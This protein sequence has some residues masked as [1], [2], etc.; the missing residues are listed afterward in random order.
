LGTPTS[1]APSRRVRSRLRAA[2]P[3]LALLVTASFLSL[4]LAAEGIRIE[5]DGG[6][7]TLSDAAGTVRQA[8]A[9]ARVKLGRTDEVTPALDAPAPADATIHVTRVRYLEETKDAVLPYKTIVRP[10]SRE[11]KPYHP[12]VTGE[13]RNGVSRKTFR[14]KVVD[15]K[16]VERVLV[17]DEVLRDPV[18]QI[19]TSRKPMILG[20]RGA[21]T[22]RRTMQ[23]VATAYDPGPGSCGK[24]ADGKTCNGKRAGYGVI[25]VDPTVIPLGSKLFVPG[26]GYGIATDVGGAIKGN[27]VDL[28][29]NSRSGSM[30]WGKKWVTVQILD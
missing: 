25:A 18:H 23:M 4:A 7:I 26:Y 5:V 6:T 13:G 11:V 19:V 21:Y 24:W 10:A 3:Y 2:A 1:A 27:H 12:T 15:G 22:G 8:L 28:G 29:F 9:L 17:S 14:V 20:S 30:K 16:D